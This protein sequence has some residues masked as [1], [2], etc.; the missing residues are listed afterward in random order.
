MLAKVK[1]NHD[2]FIWLVIVFC[3][4]DFYKV[5]AQHALIE[6]NDLLTEH[7]IEDQFSPPVASRVYLYPN[8]AAERWLNAETYFQFYPSFVV[9]EG[10]MPA[11]ALPD[12]EL[13]ACLSFTEVA[14][15]LLFSGHTF[16][17]KANAIIQKYYASK[18]GS[19]E[20]MASEAFAAETFKGMMHIAQND[21]YNK[22]LTLLRY[23]FTDTDSTWQ[24]TPPSYNDPVEPHWNTMMRIFVPKE[25]PFPHHRP[26][27][28]SMEK[29]S[30]FRKELDEVLAWH[31]A[32]S[33][34][35]LDIARHWDCNP[36]Q[37]GITG[38]IMQFAY[39]MTPAGHWISI[40]SDVMRHEHTPIKK[41]ASL[42]SKLAA[43]CYDA[44]V[45]CW[46]QKYL[47]NTIRPVTLIN[48][49]L[50]PT[51]RPS[52]E[53]PVFPEYPSGHSEVSA[54][55]SVIMEDFF[56]KE[57]AF[58][59]STQRIFRLPSLSFS[60]FHQAAEQAGVSRQYGGI[61]FKQAI[62]HGYERGIYIG[63]LHL[64]HY[65]SKLK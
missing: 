38:H 10:N 58:V 6:L 60:S 9:A 44:F 40:A 49:Y 27:P 24:P 5:R 13:T 37:L 35:T 2:A 20:W 31:A 53:T 12:A 33:N 14:A 43:V 8:L 1:R 30:P 51:W 4:M 64:K 62:L 7:L 39:R 23:T 47:F 15:K 17:P 57:Y 34:Q 65:A 54:S 16:A 41:S 42:Y 3:T 28:F 22:R 56:G 11:P 63:N 55:A 50:N 59:D 45:D 18:K 48:K 29:D 46:T 52:I 25:L 19:N 26:I 36:V 21:G 32:N 61:H